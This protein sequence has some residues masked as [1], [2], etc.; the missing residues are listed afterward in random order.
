[1][2]NDS[3]LSSNIWYGKFISFQSN[4]A[5]SVFQV[6]VFLKVFWEY[7]WKYFWKCFWKYFH[8][9]ILQDCV[10]A[11]KAI[12]DG[13]VFIARSFFDLVFSNELHAA[14]LRGSL[15]I[16]KCVLLLVL[17]KMSATR[18]WHRKG[19]PCSWSTFAWGAGAALFKLWPKAIWSYFELVYN[20]CHYFTSV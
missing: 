15:T 7:F 18:D 11:A 2:N 4:F 8:Q 5:D 10:L 12:D 9:K 17:F 3:S 13:V 6:K 20:D 16:S 19:S 1:M 14:R